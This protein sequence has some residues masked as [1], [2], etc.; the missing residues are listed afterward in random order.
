MAAINQ[1]LKEL[2]QHLLRYI[3]V[4]CAARR[5][6]L[7]LSSSSLAHSRGIHLCQFLCSGEGGGRERLPTCRHPSS[8][9]K[10]LATAN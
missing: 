8:D 7:F 9:I 2:F 4:N 5:F 1:K 10:F 6:L 3:S